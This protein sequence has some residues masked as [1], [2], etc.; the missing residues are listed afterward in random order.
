[1]QQLEG[2]SRRFEFRG[3]ANGIVFID[4]YAHHPSEL[5]A[6]LSA[7]RLQAKP[8][9]RVVA[10]P[11]RYSRTLAFYQT[12][13]SPSA[14]RIWS[15]SVRYTVL[16]NRTWGRLVVKTCRN[17]TTRD[18]STYFDVSLQFLTQTLRPG[19]LA[20]FWEPET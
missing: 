3:E 16:A 10:Q 8:E 5:R 20:L 7:A 12:L 17:T 4:D 19:D 2:A 6:T 15:L 9:A 14:M 11:H 1:L 13:L 18:V